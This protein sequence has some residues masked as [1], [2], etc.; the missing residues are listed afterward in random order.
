MPTGSIAAN[1]G[2]VIQVACKRILDILA[3]CCADE[4]LSKSLSGI[5]ENTL[6]GLIDTM[7]AEEKI[8]SVYTFAANKHKLEKKL[9][10]HF[11]DVHLS[12]QTKNTIAAL[13]AIILRHSA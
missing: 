11:P 3:T 2:E 4:K 7:C 12:Q 13:V 5:N 1:S 6:L 9:E 10:Q 8:D